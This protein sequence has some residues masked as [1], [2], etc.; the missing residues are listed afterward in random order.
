MCS[1]WIQ[2]F[3]WKLPN[4]IW[5]LRRFP[6]QESRLWAV[7]TKAG[8]TKSPPNCKPASVQIV[9]TPSPRRVAMHSWLE[10]RMQLSVVVGSKCASGFRMPGTSIIPLI[11]LQQ[12][13]SKEQKYCVYCRDRR[14]FALATSYCPSNLG[15]YDERVHGVYVF[16]AYEN[17]L[18]TIVSPR[19]RAM[20]PSVACR[21]G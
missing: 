16:P 7:C 3:A 21:Q 14:V 18:I 19:S 4:S 12:I 10:W 11:V 6:A 17:R 15:V 20:I 2:L 8:Y 5:T 9:D 13:F 1:A